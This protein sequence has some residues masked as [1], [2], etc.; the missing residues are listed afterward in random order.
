MTE[1]YAQEIGVGFLFQKKTK[2]EKPKVVEIPRDKERP[3]VNRL[4]EAQAKSIAKENSLK[5]ISSMWH[6]LS[7][8]GFGVKVSRDAG[9]TSARILTT[10][11]NGKEI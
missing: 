4:S 10:Y 8:K 3:T 2:K 11:Y 1:S 5:D 9:G 6:V 7:V